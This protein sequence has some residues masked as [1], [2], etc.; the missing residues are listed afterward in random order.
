MM[1]ETSAASSAYSRLRTL[2]G[3]TGETGPVNRD[4]I[5][6]LTQARRDGW[7]GFLS[8]IATTESVEHLL[9]DPLK[10]SFPGDAEVLD[11]LVSHSTDEQRHF[12][13][14]RDYVRTTFGFEKRRRSLSDRIVYDTFLP[15]IAQAARKRPMLALA[16]LRFYEAFSIDFY[17]TLKKLAL[18]DGLESLNTIIRS[19][20]KDELRHLA[21]LEELIRRLKARGVRPAMLDR[22]LIRTILF[23]LVADIDIRAWAIYNR[24]V[25]KRACAVGID[26]DTMSAQARKAARESMRFCK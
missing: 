22:A 14:F 6:G 18:G 3:R 15:K 26:P 11:Y 17:R 21:G 7:A 10:E 16:M 23:V 25:R 19:I 8:S 1:L 13:V 24:K 4:G 20:E 12:E 5:E 2:S 9:I